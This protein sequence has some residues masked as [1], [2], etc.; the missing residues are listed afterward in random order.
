MVSENLEIMKFA[1]NWRLLAQNDDSKFKIA[2]L[3]QNWRFAGC[4]K[5][6]VETACLLESNT[7][8]DS[9]H[10]EWQVDRKLCILLRSKSWIF[11]WKNQFVF[12]RIIFPAATD[13]I[14]LCM[15]NLSSIHRLSKKWLVEADFRLARR[16]ILWRTGQNLKVVRREQCVKF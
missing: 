2:L 12:A 5:W 6:L 11:S 1:E 3:M 15:Q 7:L 13:I 8:S 4:L 16:V 9:G 14:S 10:I